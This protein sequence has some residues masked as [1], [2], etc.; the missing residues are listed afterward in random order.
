M[1]DNVHGGSLLGQYPANHMP[2]NVCE[3]T[4]CAVVIIGEPFVVEAEQVEDS[5]VKIVNVD[6][7][8]EGLV[9]ELVGGPRS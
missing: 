4:R 3:P 6:H 2:V 8:V 9:A 7:V 1:T 5:G